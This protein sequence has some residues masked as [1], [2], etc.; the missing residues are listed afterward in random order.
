MKS[1]KS[2]L[3]PFPLQPLTL[4]DRG[5]FEKLLLANQTGDQPLAAYSFVYHFI[6]RDLFCYE[7][8]ELEGHL[9]LFSTNADGTFLALP[10]VGPDPCG[11]VIRQVFALMAERNRLPGVS[12]IENFPAALAE[13]CRSLG[14]RV[15]TKPGDYVYRCA[16]LVS[17]TGDRYKS[18]RASYNHCVKHSAPVVRPYSAADMPA[19]LR[20]FQSWQRNLDT[21][22]HTGYARD[23][24]ADSLSAHRAALSNA[25][26]LGLIGCVAEVAGQIAAYTL[27][28]PLSDSVFCVLLEIADREVHGLSQY[29]FREFCRRLSGFEFINAMDD[30]DLDG[31]RRAKRSYHPEK[32]LPSYIVTEAGG[33]SC[34]LA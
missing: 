13:Q 25:D 4:A 7:W 32:I 33:D 34:G 20:L 2:T 18:Q 14:Y 3:T 11:P 12:R 28:Y 22:P 15:L 23:L 29:I 30:S 16:D 21:R 31:L 24:A 8:V 27:G 5:W 19:C 6:W 9:C 10:A 1:E 17:L 26:E